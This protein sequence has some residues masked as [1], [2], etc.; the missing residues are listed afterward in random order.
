LKNNAAQKKYAEASDTENQAAAVSDLGEKQIQLDN[1]AKYKKEGDNLSQQAVVAYNLAKDMEAE[2]DAKQL[3]ANQ[4]EQYANDL[5]IAVK[6]NSPEALDKLEKESKEL[7]K[8]S[9]YNQNIHS[10]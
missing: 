6:S 5:E 10:R 4:S 9:N 7:E 2:A 8:K 1:A 3:E